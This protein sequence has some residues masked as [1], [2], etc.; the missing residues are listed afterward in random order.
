MNRSDLIDP[1]SLIFGAISF[2]LSFLLFY[3]YTGKFFSCIV[4]ALLSAALFWAS[5]V[6]FR[7]IY[8][9]FKR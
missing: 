1:G 2:V 8:L 6:F 5:Y 9:S 4:A 7:L 3:H